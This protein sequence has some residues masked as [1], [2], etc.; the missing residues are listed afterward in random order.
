MSTCEN[1]IFQYDYAGQCKDST[2]TMSDL[3]IGGH[4]F[5]VEG[6]TLIGWAVLVYLVVLVARKVINRY[7]QR[8]TTSATKR[9]FPINLKDILKRT[10]VFI[11]TL[12]GVGFSYKVMLLVIGFILGPKVM[13]IASLPLLGIMVYFFFFKWDRKA[14]LFS[15]PQ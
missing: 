11:L 13:L 15:K 2:I 6:L 14:S 5:R 1:I 7:K 3:V 10:S 4:F 9:H 12:V 8:D